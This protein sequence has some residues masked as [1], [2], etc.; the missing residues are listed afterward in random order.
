MP[1]FKVTVREV[2]E[3]T[4]IVKAASEEV[5]DELDTDVFA[6][7]CSANTATWIEVPERTIIDIEAMDPD[8]YHLPVE[9]D[10]DLS[11]EAV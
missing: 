9:P 5:F 7:D 3:H 4:F 6:D 2:V 8:Q 10:L 1:L 11:E